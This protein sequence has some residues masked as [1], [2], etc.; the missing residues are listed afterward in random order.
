MDYSPQSTASSV[1]YDSTL[2]HT[3]S[4]ADDIKTQHR[5]LFNPVTPDVSPPPHMANGGYSMQSREAPPARE[6][7]S[8]TNTDIQEME[9]VREHLQLM[10]QNC[11]GLT[12]QG[13]YEQAPSTTTA[14]YETQGNEAD[15][16]S[17][18]SV[19]TT[20]LLQRLLPN[21][22]PLSELQVHFQTAEQGMPSH[23]HHSRQMV[24]FSGER[25]FKAIPSSKVTSDKTLLSENS[26]LRDQ[27]EKER[28]RR[29]HC[30]QQIQELHGKLLETQQQLA[31]AVSAERKKDAMIEQLDKTLA[32][33]VDGWKKHENE[34]VAI[35][36]QLK[37]E[38]ETAEQ[39]Q[40]RQQEMLL[41]FE[42]ELAQ[43]VEAL[44]K[45]Q[46]KAAQA[47]REK[48]TQLKQQKEE[49]S[50][51]LECLSKEKETVSQME[52]EKIQVMKEK[53]EE[54]Q[55]YLQA[56]QALNEQMR[57]SEELQSKISSLEAEHK[58]TLAREKEKLQKEIQTSKD[59]Q[60]VLASVQKE[61]QRLEMELD[62]RNR[63]K[64]SLKMELRLMEAKHEANRTKEETERQ[65]ELEREMTER[66]EEIHEQM[67]KT[68]T[69]IRES[70]R[71]QLLEMN[72]KHKE[73]LEQQLS[74]FH[75]E[76]KRKDFKL[77]STTDEYEER[78]SGFQEKM[79]SLSNTRQYMEKERQA[80]SVRLQYMMQAHCDE[81]VKLLNSSATTLSPLSGTQQTSSFQFSQDH[82]SFMKGTKDAS[83]K[84][85]KD[86]ERQ[87]DKVPITAALFPSSQLQQQKQQ[88]I[89]EKSLSS[90]HPSSRPVYVT[91]DS[92]H[93]DSGMYS[94][95]Y[96]SMNGDG[97]KHGVLSH[98]QSGGLEF[99]PL[100][101]VVDNDRSI[102]GGQSVINGDGIDD[103]EGTLLEQELETDNTLLSVFHTQQQRQFSPT[104]VTTED[105]ISEKLQEQESR[106]AELNHYV[107]M[108]LQRSPGDQQY[109]EKHHL[110]NGLMLIPSTA[111]GRDGSSSSGVIS[112]IQSDH[113]TEQRHAN[114][115]L[116][117]PTS[118]SSHSYQD[119]KHTG[120]PTQP[121][122]TKTTVTP[123]AFSIPAQARRDV[124]F[125][126][127]MPSQLPHT[128]LAQVAPHTPPRRERDSDDQPPPPGAL[129]P[130]QVGQLSRMLGLFSGPGQPQLTAEQLFAYLRGVQNNSLGNNASSG[131]HPVSTKSHSTHDQHVSGPGSS[132][133]DSPPQA[134]HRQQIAANKA[135]R[136]LDTNFHKRQVQG[137]QPQGPSVS[138]HPIVPSGGQ[139]TKS[140]EQ[141]GQTKVYKQPVKQVSSHVGPP[142]RHPGTQDGAKP[143]AKPG[144]QSK[145]TK[146]KP[147]PAGKQSKINAWR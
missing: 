59:G 66:L 96:L 141:P 139:V 31:V 47:E 20:S 76:L 108:L 85:G 32:K 103:K 99:F 46:E 130:H 107:K 21:S 3:M 138:G 5:Q 40:Q 84:W 112:P 106:Q 42:K 78:I 23:D 127:Q 124:G 72:K 16:E 53:E 110:P 48:Q 91:H 56:D 137:G 30:E 35:I 123:A 88:K 98:D 104:A 22:S 6:L 54:E 105:T 25:R 133:R 58:G 29:K 14:D 65:A 75:E 97:E 1:P 26:L 67:S 87:P 57:I 33:V 117:P 45:E 128:R 52:Q 37:V 49:R 118:S 41:Q 38:R 73:D 79:A 4:V 101:A 146:V 34:K 82:S 19:E 27:V 55:K 7:S 83:F 119:V 135:R 62:T 11:K 129:T 8:M 86:T 94:A 50:K 24:S 51:L 140:A 44:T 109:E 9:Q 28:F 125:T 64:E 13:D 10:L 126:T 92:S 113:Q 17:I 18:A 120:H 115:P 70:H 81:A 100:H 63:E 122:F 116:Y 68:E 2:T 71:K 121:A 111:E 74:K 102:I 145:E 147:A 142:L 136:S 132:V 95:S 60:A 80:L 144:Q 134:S 43:A 89:P 77:K 90:L 143:A 69:E 36:N 39:S 12:D 15:K 131:P 61:V 93:T 114:T